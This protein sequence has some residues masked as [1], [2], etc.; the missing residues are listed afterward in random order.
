MGKS[1]DRG[2]FWDVFKDR[3]VVL[4]EIPAGRSRDL[5]Q[6][7][8][9]VGREDAAL[10]TRAE[11]AALFDLL[12]DGA[13]LEPGGGE[14]ELVDRAGR[15]TPAGQA[16]Q[17]YRAA[18]RGKQD[19]FDQ[20]M[21]MVHVTDWPQDSLRPEQ[22]VRSSGDAQLAVWRT[23]PGDGRHIAPPDAEGM[24]FATSTFS[25]MNSGNRT[26]RA[27]KRSWK[28]NFE[29]GDGADRLAGMTRLNLKAMFNDPAQM[30][31][32]IAWRLF[33]RAGVPASRH[34]Y[35]KLGINGNYMGLFSLVEQVDRRLL[36]DHFG[37]NDRGNLYKVY[38]G[39][40]GCGTLEHRVGQD[41]DDSGRQY[42]RPGSDDQTY[43]LKSNED[44]PAAA[45]YDD[46]AALVRAINGIGL[47]GGDRRFES[48]AFRD[49]VEGMLNARCVL[50]WAGANLLLGSWDNYFA[51]PANYYLYNS[52]VKK[53]EKDFVRSPY[54]TLV[55]WDYDNSIGIDYFQTEWQY[56]DLLDWPAATEKYCKQVS[57][58]GRVSPTPLVQ[59]LLRHQAFRQYYLDHLEH[60]L[61]TDFN[62]DS[63]TALIGPEGGPGLWE[64][65]RHAAYLESNSPYEQPFTGR[66]FT[67]DEVYRAGFKQTRLQ[68]GQAQIEGVLNFVGMR[69][70]RARRQLS[71]LRKTDPAGASGAS[72][73]V[74]MEQ[75]PARA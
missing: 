32:A 22:P 8:N 35:A 5:A 50:R 19:F 65:V 48:E 55:P 30:R 27:P 18:A 2:E 64:R 34:T 12:R 20:S 3:M 42:F 21:F 69:Y 14:V 74:V 44:D 16:F 54:F 53:G 73:P 45:A 68:H 66:Q 7:A 49:S 9:E 25:L 72:F 67:N 11:F 61:D 71:L 26:L 62:P 52:G 17:D 28:V 75:L 70:E 1:V 59:N 4:A 15:T 31:E 51:T 46:L 10:R 13:G 58:P 40:I 41:G 60:L 36:R 57:Y 63:M 39:D 23:D 6:R 33:E 43:R 37:K 47:P 29:V 38:C 24:L 56:T